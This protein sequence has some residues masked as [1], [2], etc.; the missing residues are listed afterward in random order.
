MN[1]NGRASWIARILTLTLG[2]LLF[3]TGYATADDST[4]TN[5]R[6]EIYGEWYFPKIEK[7]GVTA[8]GSFLIEQSRITATNRCS[9]RS[10]T[11]VVR[12]ASPA[13][14]TA[15]Q[16]TVLEAKYTD[17]GSFPN[18]EI[19]LVRGTV[20]YRVQNGRLFFSDPDSGETAEF[21]RRAP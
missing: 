18:C 17:K 16:L 19:S 2:A 11:V 6:G 15:N 21:T 14:I 8:A 4:A 10:V 20:S 3:L 12:V 1:R 13:R 5:G 7:F 9:L